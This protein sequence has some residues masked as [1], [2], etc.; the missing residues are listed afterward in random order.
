MKILVMSLSNQSDY[1]EFHIGLFKIL[2][3]NLKETK[4]KPNAFY[5]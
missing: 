3:E 2:G 5:Q 1:S 4:L